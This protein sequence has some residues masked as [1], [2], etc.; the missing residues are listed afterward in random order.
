M[1]LVSSNNGGNNNMSHISNLITFN[2]SIPASSI[3]GVTLEIGAGTYAILFDDDSS[4]FS[5]V[6]TTRTGAGTQN[7]PYEYSINSVN[8]S[9]ISKAAFNNF[10]NNNTSVASFENESFFP[11]NIVSVPSNVVGYTQEGGSTVDV[12]GGAGV[13]YAMIPTDTGWSL[14]PVNY[15]AGASTDKYT[16][17]PNGAPIEGF[18]GDDFFIQGAGIFAVGSGFTLVTE[19]GATA[20]PD[21]PNT[22]VD[23]DIRAHYVNSSSNSTDAVEGIAAKVILKFTDILGNVTETILSSP[24]E[25]ANAGYRLTLKSMDGNQI[26]TE[27]ESAGNEDGIYLLDSGSENL[28]SKLDDDLKFHLEYDNNGQWEDRGYDSINVKAS[29]G[30]QYKIM[31]QNAG[32]TDLQ[33]TPDVDESLT[34]KFTVVNNFTGLD[35]TLGADLKLNVFH[36]DVTQGT[37]PFSNAGISQI[38]NVAIAN[39]TTNG[40]LFNFDTTTSAFM[41]AT[42][43]DGTGATLGSNGP[44]SISDFSGNEGTQTSQQA[45]GGK[46]SVQTMLNDGSNGFL[47]Q[48]DIAVGSNNSNFF[49]IYQGSYSEAAPVTTTGVG[50]QPTFSVSLNADQDTLTVSNFHT[51]LSNTVAS[52]ISLIG[53]SSDGTQTTISSPT[54]TGNATDGFAIDLAGTS[55]FV[56]VAAKIGDAQEVVPFNSDYAAFGGGGDDNAIGIG[57]GDTFIGGDGKDSAELVGAFQDFTFEQ[58]TIQQ[59]EA[60]ID[61]NLSQLKREKISGTVDSQDDNSLRDLLQGNTP[62]GAPVF[63]L[64]TDDFGTGFPAAD[65]DFAILGNP[66][67]GFSLQGGTTTNGVFSAAGNPTSVDPANNTTIAQFLGDT[68]NT[69]VA[70]YEIPI[71]TTN[72]QGIAAPYADSSQIWAVSNTDTD[73]STSFVQAENIFFSDDPSISMNIGAAPQSVFHLDTA[74]TYGTHVA[75]YYIL[76]GSLDD[77]AMQ[78]VMEHP[79]G[80]GKYDLMDTVQPISI[81]NGDYTTISGLTPAGTHKPAYELSEKAVASDPYNVETVTVN[82]DAP[83]GDAQQ[84][85][86]QI[87]VNDSPNSAQLSDFVETHGYVTV[88]GD[89]TSVDINIKVVNDGDQD[90]SAEEFT[91][92]LGYVIGPNKIESIDFQLSA[93]DGTSIET[94]GTAAGDTGTTLDLTPTLANTETVSSIADTI[95]PG[96]T[97]HVVGDPDGTPGNA[98]DE[99]STYTSTVIDS[100]SDGR[101]DKIELDLQSIGKG[102]L[103][104]VGTD[105]LGQKLDMSSLAEDSAITSD[106][107]SFAASGSN[108]YLS[109]ASV[110]GVIKGDPL[111]YYVFTGSNYHFLG[112]DFLGNTVKKE[113]SKTSTEV[114]TFDTIQQALNHA[115]TN[116]T[117]NVAEI[118][119]AVN[120]QENGNNVLEI[121]NDNLKIDFWDEW[122]NSANGGAGDAYNHAAGSTLDFKMG[123]GVQVVEFGGIR[124]LNIIGNELDNFISGNKGNN[125]I[126]G[127]SGDDVILGGEGDDYIKG[128]T[129][130]DFIDGQAGADRIY[131]QR[132]DDLLVATGETDDDTDDFISGGSGD[133]V[134][135][136]AANKT[137]GKVTIIAGSGNDL[138]SVAAARTNID[139]QAGAPVSEDTYEVRKVNTHLVDLT[140][141]DGLDIKGMQA[142][143]DDVATG[144]IDESQSTSMFAASEITLTDLDSNDIANRTTV[145]SST[146]VLSL[147][148][149]LEGAGATAEGVLITGIKI[150]DIDTNNDG[151]TDDVGDEIAAPIL[152][153]VGSIEV[154]LGTGTLLATAQTNSTDSDGLGQDL[155]EGLD[156]DDQDTNN[157]GPTDYD[158]GISVYG[159]DDALI[160]LDTTA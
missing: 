153:V 155:F 18:G 147:D 107:L 96:T 11:L 157:G 70:E 57:A 22:S 13:Y 80:S 128:G 112:T 62:S 133:D 95:K 49:D 34:Q 8:Y 113:V 26:I 86:W 21:L 132:G 36:G 31:T 61:D 143:V 124:D 91:V 150:D 24:S 142:A 114:Q 28:I 138:V 10:Y 40:A 149:G 98:D 130:H 115:N 59:T 99:L 160:W 1:S 108:A 19:N 2:N 56:K 74:D 127:G 52:D 85:F 67:E 60:V 75:G 23:V 154:S 47:E 119:I 27:S 126:F 63:T 151:D 4:H 88:A 140:T 135:V 77:Y 156:A 81:S 3:A 41:Y 76:G 111:E 116:S 54:I 17:N 158:S 93:E 141:S 39:E 102:I 123:A 145:D 29:A 84:L 131:G 53:I 68:N 25:I 5:L 100:D 134:L 87:N 122:D 104:V 125:E 89:A 32:N 58:V 55:A 51:D 9:G 30:S 44:I 159:S 137:T 7:D 92:D 73:A 82:L 50:T 14:V 83:F 42:V 144:D 78:Q 69:T 71:D 79:A 117:S 66:E 35:A 65:G 152:P 20:M 48:S 129:G 110:Q 94:I 118:R 121:K 37:D 45:A 38:S 15:N 64:S 146:N 139:F 101:I 148:L 43:N 16:L 103:N 6:G 106:D 90:E 97:D 72:I 136:D 33:S 120:H 109:Q 105:S 12:P 46:V